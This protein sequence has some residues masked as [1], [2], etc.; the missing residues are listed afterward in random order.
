MLMLIGVIRLEAGNDVRRGG[1]VHP[2]HAG[3]L[4]RGLAPRRHHVQNFILLVR[5]ELRGPATD[6]ALT[7]GVLESV[8]RALAQ[9]GAEFVFENVAHDSEW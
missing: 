5:R 2:V 6:A 4:R 3:R 9:L 1:T 8:T 7:A